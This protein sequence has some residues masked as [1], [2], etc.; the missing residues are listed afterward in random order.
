MAKVASVIDCVQPYLFNVMLVGAN[1]SIW[2]DKFHTEKFGG[3]RKSGWSK[4]NVQLVDSGDMEHHPYTALFADFV[5]AIR[6]DR[7][8]RLTLES[9]ILS[10][11]A[12]LAADLAREGGRPVKLSEFED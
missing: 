2:N 4:L 6:E 9:S 5:D 10:H 7:E 3:L 12:C 11:K 1:G 8:P